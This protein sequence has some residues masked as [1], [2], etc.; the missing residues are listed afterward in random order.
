MVIQIE[1]ELWIKLRG[2]ELEQGLSA[3]QIKHITFQLTAHFGLL[4][5]GGCIKSRTIFL[6]RYSVATVEFFVGRFG[7]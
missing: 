4:K 2:T 7:V 3:S 5:E 6:G 1:E